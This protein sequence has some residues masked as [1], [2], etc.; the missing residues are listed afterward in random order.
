MVRRT[1]IRRLRFELGFKGPCAIDDPAQ[2][3][4]H[5]AENRSNAGEKKHRRHGQLDDA[6]NATEFNRVNHETST[7]APWKIAATLL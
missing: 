4:R 5:H 6:R 7:A 1:G 3:I 2:P